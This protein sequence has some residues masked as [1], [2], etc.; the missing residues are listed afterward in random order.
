M[1]IKKIF[2]KTLNYQVIV[3]IVTHPNEYWLQWIT[4]TVIGIESKSESLNALPNGQKHGTRQL[5]SR[6]IPKQH[7]VNPHFSI[8]HTVEALNIEMSQVLMVKLDWEV[9]YS[10]LNETLLSSTHLIIE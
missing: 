1:K 2:S 7:A 9:I 6:T 8:H 5:S 4:P 3:H 10:S